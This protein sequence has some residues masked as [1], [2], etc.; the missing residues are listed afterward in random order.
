MD[1]DIRGHI[2]YNTIRQLCQLLKWDFTWEGR[3]LLSYILSL[4]SCLL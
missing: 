2:Q 3:V 1:F 4:P